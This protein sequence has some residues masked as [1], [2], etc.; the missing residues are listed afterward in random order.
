MNKSR[1]SLRDIIER[2]EPFD[3]REAADIANVLAWLKSGAEVYRRAKPDV[4]PKHLVSYVVVVDQARRSVLLLDH[5]K[6]DLWVPPGGHVEPNEDPYDAAVRELAEELGPRAAL[7]AS[8]ARL[9]LFVTMTRTR[10][11]GSHL[12]VSLWYVVA[13]DERMWLEPDPREFRGHRWAGYEDVLAMDT[14]ELDAGMH[15][16]IRKLQRRV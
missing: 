1:T 4:P 3:E 6:A 14:G 8:V 11:V 10:G 15:R 9:P 7:V 12:D 16:F 5:V 2:V 13:G